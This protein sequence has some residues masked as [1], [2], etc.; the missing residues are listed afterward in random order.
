MIKG[1]GFIPISF[2]L[3]EEVLKLPKGWKIIAVKPM[4]RYGYCEG[5]FEIVVE[6]EGIPV[7]EEGS[8]P[9]E[10]MLTYTT[11]KQATTLDKRGCSL[12]GINIKT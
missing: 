12:T 6:G 2:A 1:V 9:P 7:K 3:I 11:D 10:I 4:D 8:Y 5:K